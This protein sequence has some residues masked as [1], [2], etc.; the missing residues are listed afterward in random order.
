MSAP[1]LH[2]IA[3]AHGTHDAAGRDVIDGLRADLA[4]LLAAEGPGAQVHEAYVDVQS[5]SLDEVVAAL[6][7]GSR[8]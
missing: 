7:R 5:P 2:V 3:C 4:A 1:V 6:P 8:P